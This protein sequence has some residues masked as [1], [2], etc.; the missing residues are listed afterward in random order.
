MIK[1]SSSDRLKNPNTSQT[2]YLTSIVLITVLTSAVALTTGFLPLFYFSALV[3]CFGILWIVLNSD[4]QD[5]DSDDITDLPINTPNEEEFLVLGNGRK[6]FSKGSLIYGKN[7]LLWLQSNGNL[8]PNHK[9]A[10]SKFK[11]ASIKA[12]K[13][14]DINEVAG[15][16][17]VAGSFGASELMLEKKDKSK[18]KFFINDPELNILLKQVVDLSKVGSSLTRTLSMNG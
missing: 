5:F 15:F 8:L 16:K 17:F 7:Q 14:S 10:G 1:K 3:F 18:N 12:E 13:I 2:S 6:N 4:V 9:L 11:E